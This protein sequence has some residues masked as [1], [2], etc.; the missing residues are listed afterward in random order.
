MTSKP[1]IQ[2]LIANTKARREWALLNGNTV[3]AEILKA[4]IVEL[5]KREIY[6]TKGI[7]EH[8]VK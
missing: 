5:I 8:H 4:Q 1:L 2:T 6:E 7:G 3:E